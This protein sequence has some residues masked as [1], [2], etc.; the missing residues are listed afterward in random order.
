MGVFNK[1]K[2]Y[3]GSSP[4]L[5]EKIRLLQN[6]EKKN[7]KEGMTTDKMYSIVEPIPELPPVPPVMTDVPDP[8]GVRTAGYVQPDGGFDENDPSTWDNAF[9]DTSWMY[10]SNEVMGETGRPVVASVDTTWANPSGGAAYGAGLVRTHIYYGDSLGYLGNDG[11]YQQLLS[12]SYW[13]NMVPPHESQFGSAMSGAHYYGITGAKKAAM[14]SAYAQMQALDAAGAATIPIK[15]WVPWSYFWYGGTYESYSGVKQGGYI[16]KNASL[17]A[18][19]PQYESE[20]FKPHTPAWNKVIQQKALG[21]GNDPENFPGVITVIGKLFKSSK[22]AIDTMLSKGNKSIQDVDWDDVGSKVNTALTIAD[23]GLTVVS[24][25]GIIIPEPTTSAAGAAGLASLISKFRLAGK[26]GKGAGLARGLKGMKVG[27]TGLKSGG[28]RAIK[29]GAL[30]KGSKGLLTPKGGGVYSAPTVGKVGKTALTPGSGASRYAHGAKTSNPI[31]T[32]SDK[33]RGI[34]PGASEAPGGVVGS[35][36]PGGARGINF[37]E[38]QS[39]VNPKTFQKGNR[40]LRD[41]MGGKHKNSPTA[42]RIMKMAQDAGFTGGSTNIPFKK[43]LKQAFEYEFIDYINYLTEDVFDLDE[44]QD[45]IVMELMKNPKFVERLPEIVKGMEEELELTEL[46]Y[47]LTGELEK[48]PKVVYNKQDLPYPN[49]TEFGVNP[50]LIKKEIP[51]GSV[52]QHPSG[53]HPE[54]PH[55]KR[56]ERARKIKIKS[57]DL[58]RQYKV[59]PNEITQYHATIDAINHFIDTRPAKAAAIAERYPFYDPRL[60]ELN[61]KLDQMMD[62]STEYV[63]SKF[64]E[65]KKA[66]SRIIKIMKKTVEMTDPKS[67]KKDP[68]PPTHSD[69]IQLR[70]RESATRHF[71]KPVQIKSWHKGHLTKP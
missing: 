18:G 45:E 27:A 66:T 55:L 48:D 6:E 26:L 44:R 22:Q 39:V 67:F 70:L 1:T 35:L 59:S 13:G 23:I 46:L 5:E 31:K 14:Q 25:I 62:A 3:R 43:L 53:W 51:D 32:L 19:A 24:I 58:I 33:I 49:A 71:K 10:N 4:E 8:N 56:S 16:L 2:K 34:K 47:M 7:I 36:T 68:T 69:Y 38:P 20:P 65:N 64:P 12:A 30:H 17:Y 40:I 41:I 60:A 42:Q 63:A 50:E 61:W 54:S 15:M 11:T 29:G 28:Y 52:E 9:Q 57:Q 21:D 37:I